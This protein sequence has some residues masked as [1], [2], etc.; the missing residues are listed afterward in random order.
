MVNPEA[1]RNHVVAAAILA[2]LFAAGACGAQTPPRGHLSLGRSIQVMYWP[3]VV[4]LSGQLVTTP[5]YGSPGFGED[6]ARDQQIAVPILRLTSPIDVRS[7]PASKEPDT[8]TRDSVTIVQLIFFP[9]NP[10]RKHKDLV[11]HQVVVTGTLHPSSTASH[12]TPVI[13]WV[14]KIEPQV[15]GSHPS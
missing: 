2:V 3:A 7:N 12:Y 4:R 6:T 9:E 15:G 1:C 14:E 11:G 8:T 10:Y 13:L 5:A